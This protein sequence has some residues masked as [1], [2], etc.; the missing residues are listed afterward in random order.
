MIRLSS[1]LHLVN[2][3][4]TVTPLT[5]DSYTIRLLLVRRFTDSYSF[6]VI[7]NWDSTVEDDVCLLIIKMRDDIN[8]SMR[9][10]FKKQL[11]DTSRQMKKKKERKLE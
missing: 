10:G 7:G 3:I 8:V 1:D 11:V 5:T 6:P 9:R 2:L 4:F